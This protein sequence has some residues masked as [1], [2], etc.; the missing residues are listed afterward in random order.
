MFVPTT[1][2]ALALMVNPLA[3]YSN[4]P[5][6]N[7]DETTVFAVKCCIKEKEDAVGLHLKLKNVIMSNLLAKTV[8][9]RSLLSENLILVLQCQ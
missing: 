4:D 7:P 1:K 6:S 5:S 9:K 3:L 8:C 2:N